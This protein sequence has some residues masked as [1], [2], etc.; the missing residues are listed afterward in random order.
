MNEKVEYD[1]PED[2]QGRFVRTATAVNDDIRPPV[3][4]QRKE[5]PK[6]GG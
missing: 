6:G 2:D 3:W 5:E 1:V 4:L